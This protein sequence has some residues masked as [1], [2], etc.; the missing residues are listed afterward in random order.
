MPRGDK[1]GN[2]KMKRHRAARV[3][4]RLRQQGVPRAESN[5]M[6]T[7]AMDRE[8]ERTG[9]RDAGKMAV[10]EDAHDS[11]SGHIPTGPPPRCEHRLDRMHIANERRAWRVTTQRY[12]RRRED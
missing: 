1:S 11:R 5:R 4:D 6:A 10:N 7:A 9:P 3:A 12:G 8:Y 2:P